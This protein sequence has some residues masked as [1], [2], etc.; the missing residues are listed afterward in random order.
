MQLN[1]M[2]VSRMGW[3]DHNLR[4]IKP[5]IRGICEQITCVVRYIHKLITV[6]TKRMH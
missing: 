1:L 3:M 2:N 4:K 5:V 6:L